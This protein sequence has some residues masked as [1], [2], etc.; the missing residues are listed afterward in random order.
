MDARTQG[1]AIR[2]LATLAQL[3]QDLSEEVVVVWGALTLA[4]AKTSLLRSYSK[5]QEACAQ[6]ARHPEELLRAASLLGD[7][8]IAS[9]TLLLTLANVGVNV[10]L[11]VT[12][13]GASSVVA[14]FAGQGMLKNL[15][16]GVML[17][18]TE[19]P[20]KTGDHVV[21]Y[22]SDAGCQICEGTVIAI[23]ATFTELRP[24]G[25][26]GGR[27]IVNNADMYEK[28]VLHNKSADS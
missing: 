13:F 8:C 5:R 11:L 2:G 1:R 23:H 21:L 9:A 20:L 24:S 28:F 4:D 15:I 6:G 12:S 16:A 7:V 10:P 14:G 17:Y 26:Q 25:Q 22:S 27:L 18:T 3:L 19:R